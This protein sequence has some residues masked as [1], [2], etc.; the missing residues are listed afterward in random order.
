MDTENET[1]PSDRLIFAP[2][3]AN[4]L[5]NRSFS[6]SLVNFLLAD[7]VQ[8]ILFALIQQM[9]FSDHNHRD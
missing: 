4:R 2:N 8:R 6:A 3:A 5:R 1:Y 7:Q 9:P